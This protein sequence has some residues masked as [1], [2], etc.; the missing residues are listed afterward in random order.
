MFC[1]AHGGG[2]RCQYPAGC[3]KGADGRTMFCIAH[4]GGRHIAMHAPGG[5]G[6]ALVSVCI[7]EYLRS[8]QAVYVGIA[9]IFL[10]L[11]S[12]AC[13]EELF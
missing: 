7:G 4:G 13:L 1:K 6:R 8:K 3:S 11:Y 10:L 12:C 2:K 5:W 9:M